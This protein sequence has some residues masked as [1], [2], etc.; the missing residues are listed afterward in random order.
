MGLL[1]GKAVSLIFPTYLDLYARNGRGEEWLFQLREWGETLFPYSKALAFY[2]VKHQENNNDDFVPT[3]SRSF[4]QGL[5]DK[6]RRMNYDDDDVAINV[7]GILVKDLLFSPFWLLT[8]PS[9]LD[10]F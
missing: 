2:A 3:L 10:Y 9:L 6:A 5:V 1:E 4:H 7:C 8:L